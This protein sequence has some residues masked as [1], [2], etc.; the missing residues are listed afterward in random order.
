[1]LHFKY[2]NFN[3]HFFFMKMQLKLHAYKIQGKKQK[4]NLFFKMK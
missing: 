4:E 1:M 2:V 3:H